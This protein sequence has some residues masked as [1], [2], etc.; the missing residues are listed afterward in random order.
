MFVKAGHLV[1]FGYGDEGDR[2]CIY[3]MATGESN[4]VK[5]DGVNYVMCIYIAYQAAA[6][7]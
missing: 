4:A 3:N 2:H 1:V 5:A 7:R 6:A